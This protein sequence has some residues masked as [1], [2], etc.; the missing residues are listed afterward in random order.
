MITS[1]ELKTLNEQYGDYFTKTFMDTDNGRNM[2]M[3]KDVL[4]ALKDGKKPP[5]IP[6]YNDVFD[7]AD[8]MP[9]S[10]EKLFHN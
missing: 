9:D 4:L 2:E 3:K 6:H 1:E 10:L 7:R 5:E 8:P